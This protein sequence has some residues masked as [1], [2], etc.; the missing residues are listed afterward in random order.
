MLLIGKIPSFLNYKNYCTIHH[1]SKVTPFMR[2]GHA[3]DTEVGINCSSDIS[4][5]NSWPH[6]APAAYTGCGIFV[7]GGDREGRGGWGDKHDSRPLPSCAAAHVP[8]R[9]VKSFFY[10]T[11]SA[12]TTNRA[13]LVFLKLNSC[14]L[15]ISGWGIYLHAVLT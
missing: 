10:V 3:L 4:V 2:P 12:G 13:Y 5:Y 15:Q 1:N 6:V 8:Y 7:R 9:A 14:Q 11:A